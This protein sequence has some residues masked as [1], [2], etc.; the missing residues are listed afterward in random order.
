MLRLIFVLVTIGISCQMTWSQNSENSPYSRFG[1]GNLSDPFLTHQGTMGGWSAAFNDPNLINYLNP[2]S[3]ASLKATSFEVGLFGRYNTLRDDLRSTNQWGGNLSYFSLAFPIKNPLN[4]AFD[5]RER[6]FFWGSGLTLVPYSNV[7]Y[8]ITTTD[9]QPNIGRVTRQYTG[10]GGT[11]RLLIS[12]GWKYKKLSA[13]INTGIV[14]GQLR[15]NR[16]VFLEDFT[17]HSTDLFEETQLINAFTLDLGFQYEF[18]FDEKKRKETNKPKKALTLGVYGNNNRRFTTEFS[19]LIH[20][21]NSATDPFIRDTLFQI[22]GARERGTL[23]LSI[24][25]GIGYGIDAKFRGGI[26]YNI[27]R[28][29][30]FANPA[31]TSDLLANTWM[32]NGGVEYIPNANAIS[33][34]LKKVRYRAGFKYGSDPRVVAGE[35]LQFFEISTGMGMPFIVAREV[36]QLHIG[37]TYGQFG[38]PSAPIKESY[39]RFNFGYTFL[40]NSWF[41]KRR[42]Y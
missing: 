42:F 4:D 1:L 24:T 7:S 15:K 18:V 19:Q 37:F 32:V 26:D 3:L 16:V 30:N 29:A 23:P 33:G 6:K 39:F 34:Y 14:F 22:D 31:N 28:W 40:D 8:N 35:Q 11:Y 9:F 38:G 21:A 25:G 27:T 10:E 36:S 13:G 41:V 5:R 12:N 20:R 17:N 2:A